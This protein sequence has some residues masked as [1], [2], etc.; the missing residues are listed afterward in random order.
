MSDKL[1]LIVDDLIKDSLEVEHA[2]CLY[3]SC[4]NEVPWGI[5]PDEYPSINKFLTLLIE[6]VS[7]Y[8]LELPILKARGARAGIRRLIR[9]NV[10][11]IL[12][13]ISD[14]LIRVLRFLEY[15]EHARI[16]LINTRNFSPPLL[17]T[18][19]FPLARDSWEFSQYLV[20]EILFDCERLEF[21]RKN[22]LFPENYWDIGRWEQRHGFNYRP[23]SRS[24]RTKISTLLRNPVT[25]S[26]SKGQ[27]LLH[28]A[29]WKISTRGKALPID[30]LG[31]NEFFMLTRGFFWPLGKFCKLSD[32]MPV[33]SDG[34]TFDFVLREH[35]SEVTLPYFVQ[36]MG[37]YLKKVGIKNSFFYKYLKPISHLFFQLYPISM[38]E[39]FERNYIWAIQQL[40]K[41]QIKH[42]ISWDSA[43]SDKAIYYNCAATDSG[44]K[45][46]GIQ[47][48][49]WGG[50]LANVP[51]I[52]EVSITGTDYYITS[53]W[54]HPEPHLPSWK[55]K[56]IPLSSPHYSEMTKKRRQ[57]TK[58]NK[59][60][61]LATGEAFRFPPVFYN[62]TLYP[63]NFKKWADILE[64]VIEC[65]KREK[66]HII[67]KNYAPNVTEFL[68][69]QGVINK[70]L[71]AGGKN[72]S[73]YNRDE[74][75]TAKNL[76]GEV[77]A[78]IWDIPAAGFVESILL[79]APTFS[80]WSS[81]FSRCQPVGE[82]DIAKLIDVGILNADGADMARNVS[83]CIMQKDWWVE[84][85]RRQAVDSFMTKF[86][87]TN[88]EWVHEWKEFL[89]NL[90]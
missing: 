5:A 61:L 17:F 56:A 82:S 55:V 43:S 41:F 85:K 74:K 35:L 53:G 40:K 83:E 9:A 30:A 86:I 67:I 89:S 31:Y 88:S 3:P 4:R 90:K 25:F 63:D 87:K 77:N 21:S 62:G 66:L 32:K 37:E 7:D 58:R 10:A 24:I 84:T 22:S 76:F 42:Y 65:L 80:L 33:I 44:Y 28:S 18:H 46:W 51:R 1:L 68:T 48:S 45:V 11:Q 71:R 13:I 2:V 50:Y 79:G 14:R 27:D 8:L 39:G 29:I 49:A 70:W 16:T 59:T 81:D 12:Y 47:H 20:N 78:T 15:N 26:F 75:G 69:Q 57:S 54:S 72:L 19:V 60:V 52:A 34:K 23:K 6:N 38:L 64:E 36:E 73:I